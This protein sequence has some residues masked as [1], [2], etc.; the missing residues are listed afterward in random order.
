MYF[1][2]NSITPFATMTTTQKQ[3]KLLALLVGI[4]A[5]KKPITPL[6]GCINDVHKIA[7]FLQKQDKSF[8]VEIVTLI[9][10]EATKANI[11][12]GFK[13]HLGS[14]KKDDS[15]LFY[16]SGHGTQENANSVFWPGES[17]KKLESLVCYDG[18][19]LVEGKPKMNLLADK[20]LRFLIG[21]LATTNPNILTI[22]DCC[23]SGTNTRNGSFSQEKNGI[24]ERKVLNRL[25][26]AFP[27]RPWA[28]FIFSEQISQK[29]VLEKGSHVAIKEGTHIQMA[30]CQND[31]S[32]FEVHGEGVFTKN[33]IDILERCNG[34]IS[35]HRL[36]S[37]I[38]S[39][40]RHQFKQTPKIYVVG[41]E[42]ALFSG[43]LNKE[44][45]EKE[46]HGSVSFNSDLGWILDMGSLQG[47]NIKK[48]I[49]LQEEESKTTY[50]AQISEVSVSYSKVS[51]LSDLDKE[52]DTSRIFKATIDGILGHNIQL[53]IMPALLT[54]TRTTSLIHQIQQLTSVHQV[55][56]K[57]EAD[58]CLLEQDECLVLSSPENT[59]IPIVPPISLQNWHNSNATQMK[60]YLEHLSKYAFVKYLNNPAAFLLRPDHISMQI[61]DGDTSLPIVH[62]EIILNY[63][64]IGDTWGGSIR[65]KLK[66][67]SQKKLYV[68]LCYLSFNFGVYARL[69]PAGVV[70]LD[71]GSEIWALDGASIQL[72]LEPEVIPFNYRQSISYLK[73]LIS[74]E[75]FTQQLYTL[76][77]D[78]LP[79]PV[80]EKKG[81]RGLALNREPQII[82]DWTSKLITLRMPNP[83]FKTS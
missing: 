70:G 41:D 50:K 8:Q 44:V 78:D 26:M 64:K 27:E 81:T 10:D 39:Y 42:S 73:L 4:D 29:D 51:F 14:A 62:D 56:L 52:M 7:G 11:V 74:T 5:Y 35:Y 43:F 80:E 37:T 34:A 67:T 66:N 36:Q 72:K 68:A 22:F 6:N 59:S 63:V 18:L 58:Y 60:S 76:S 3:P 12:E 54:D 45:D 65:V 19:V 40:L 30:A 82:H 9:N 23:H 71:A 75:D 46:L 16:Y 53:Y 17:D 32:A 33:L 83:E 2:M 24:L 49:S 21:E 48:E 55:D 57:A 69:L 79:S 61:L 20:E 31:E 77:L 28:D 1:S 47:L 25:S 13:T 38:Q 15:V